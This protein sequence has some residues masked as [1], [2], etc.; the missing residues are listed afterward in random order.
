[1]RIRDV[2]YVEKHQNFWWAVLYVTKKRENTVILLA[3]YRLKKIGM[4]RGGQ[5]L[6][7]S[8]QDTFYAWYIRIPNYLQK[9]QKVAIQMF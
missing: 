4:I 9:L 6:S 7:L 5:N 8:I 3:S 2:S 1:M